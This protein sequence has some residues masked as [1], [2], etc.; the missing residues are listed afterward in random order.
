MVLEIIKY[1]HPALR[2]RGKK[3]DKITGEIKQLAAD[4]LETMR[5]N[6][7]V[8]LAAQQVG[9]PLQLMVVDVAGTD[10]P[11][12]MEIDDKPAAAETLM[13]LVLINPVISEP[14]GEQIGGEG[15]LSFPEIVAD[16]KRA[17]RVRVEAT[18]LEGKRYH[19][20]CTGLLSR[21]SQHELDHLNGIL[22]IDRMDSATKASLSG[23]LKRLQKETKA[24]LG[25]R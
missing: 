6:A 13:P 14:E 21:A 20:H 2:T 3:V 17:D 24:Q 8:G 5:Q 18:N 11:W 15:C 7:G 23:R 12:T 25:P 10:R 1:G 16:I 9:K 22:F 4:M 19:F